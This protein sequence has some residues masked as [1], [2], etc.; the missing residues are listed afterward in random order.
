MDRMKKV[1]LLLNTYYELLYKR[2]EA[3]SNDCKE[4]VRR[5]LQEEID[6][7][8]WE[9]FGED[10]F[11]AYQEA[12]NAFIMERLEMYNPIGTQYL[13][14]QG[15]KT[16]AF[17]LEL[18][19]NWYDSRG[20]YRHLVES[21]L[22]KSDVKGFEQ[23]LPQLAQELIEEFGAYPDQSIIAGYKVRPELNKL[24]DYVVARV[25]EKLLL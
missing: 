8:G 7:Q 22:E 5:V 25:I 11:A 16:E 23:K 10:K 15:N 2:L 24:P 6:K 3:K 12:C 4:M 13:F 18:A 17:E 20:E 21:A 9:Q 1:K 19:I 14:D